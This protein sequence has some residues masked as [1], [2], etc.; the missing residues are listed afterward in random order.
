[1]GLMDGKVVLISGG[2]RGQ[3]RAHAVT[4][5]REG[6]DVVIFDICDEISSSAVPLA[7]REDLETTRRM[8][9]DLD[10]RCI[11]VKADARSA[12]QVEG[13]VARAMEDLGKIDAVSINHGIATFGSVWELTERQFRDQLEVN[14]LAPFIV[15][16]A[17]IPQMVERGEG[18]AIVI[19]A[20]AASL[21]AF[22][23]FGA[24]AA[25]KHGVIGLM[26]TLAVELAPHM[27]RANAIC[28]GTINTPMVHHPSSYEAMTGQP[29]ATWED[30]APMV[31][32]FQ[33]LP[34][35]QLEPEDVSNALLYLMSD[36]GRYTTGAILSVDGG[37]VLK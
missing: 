18:G 30:A 35:D 2:A 13:V 6:A 33:K 7:T 4:M 29:D 9:E 20:S 21:I 14:T 28:P 1:M 32:R 37:L 16:K 5:A 10:R 11:A 31:R 27:I 12:D 24:Y 25:A 36:M 22:P 26:K 19:T 17:V 8:V 23:G 3:G 34:I 15:A